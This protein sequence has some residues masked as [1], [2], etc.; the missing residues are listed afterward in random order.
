MDNFTIAAPDAKTTDILLDMIDDK[1][2][3]LVKCQGY[4]DMY[5][6]IDVL[7]TRH[8]I[9]ISVRSFIN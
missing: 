3:I 5:S 9:K 6:G 7:Q 4:L 8:Y 1:L 2:K